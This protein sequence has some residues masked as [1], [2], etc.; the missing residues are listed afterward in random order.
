MIEDGERRPGVFYK[1]GRPHHYECQDC[2]K[3]DPVHF[4]VKDSIWEEA[5]MG[6]G[7]I[8]PE[9]FE[10][11]LGRRLGI[12]DFKDVPSND[13]FFYGYQM[14]KSLY[15]NPPFIAIATSIKRST[16]PGEEVLETGLTF[17]DYPSCEFI[18][19]HFTILDSE[20]KKEK[21]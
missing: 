20:D 3:P 19:A 16:H 8:C 13:M 6:K 18:E 21:E 15:Y 5:G 1:D 2:K 17:P 14:A 4:M 10:I 7:I 12:Q 11:R 9:C